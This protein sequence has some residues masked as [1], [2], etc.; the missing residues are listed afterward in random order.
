MRVRHQGLAF[1]ISTAALSEYD[2][3]GF[4][5]VQTRGFAG[6]ASGNAPFELHSTFGFLS[7]PDDPDPGPD[8]LGC[9]VLFGVEGDDTHAWLSH[10][11]RYL[12][13]V[14]P[15]KKGGSVH[16]CKTGAFASFDGETGSYTLYVPYA[17]DGETPTKAMTI[18]VNVDAAGEENIAI[19]HGDGSAVLLHNG[20]VTMKSKAGGAGW[21]SV[22]EQGVNIGGTFN[23]AGGVTAGGPAASPVALATPL[24]A[25][26]ATV[27]A[28]MTAVGTHL[29]A[30]GAVVGNPA[31]A[32]AATAAVTAG[33][34]AAGTL[35]AKT[36]MGA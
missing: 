14:P 20:A 8:G 22:D 19:V 1:D 23:A 13:R 9:Q 11:P 16:Y 30:P 36:T 4:P 28:F 5:S 29:G 12:P 26:M 3:D 15:L 31:T 25:W 7:R 6:E 2:G 27:N 17:F 21:I 32:T 24:L 34:A 10:D 35:A 18:A 33:A